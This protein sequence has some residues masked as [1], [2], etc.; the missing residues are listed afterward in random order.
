M[1]V[2]KFKVRTAEFN[3]PNLEN[4]YSSLNIYNSYKTTVINITP[5]QI[6]NLQQPLMILP[7]PGVNNY[8][9]MN[10]VS[11]S[12]DFNSTPYVQVEDPGTVNFFFGTTQTNAAMD[13]STVFESLF[14]SFSSVSIS[15]ESNIGVNA[16][17]IEDIVNMGIYLVSSSGTYVLNGDSPIKIT[18]HYTVNSL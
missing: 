1:S 3:T 18:L 10:S 7:P 15:S 13:I 4:L 14:T 2:S 11:V 17:P 8:Y 6:L 16:Q 12:L 5:E 9:V